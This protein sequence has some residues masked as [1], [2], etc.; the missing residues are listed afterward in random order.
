MT[1]I[2][3]T[4][5]TKVVRMWNNPYGT[6]IYF[7]GDMNYLRILFSVYTQ[8]HK[9]IQCSNNSIYTKEMCIFFKRHVEK[10]S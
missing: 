1:K 10:Y 4:G 2:I 3:K 8:E 5:N 7:A 9:H 6:L